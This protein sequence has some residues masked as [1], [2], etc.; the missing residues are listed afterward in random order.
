MAT[1]T[2]KQQKTF[3][4]VRI[5]GGFAAASCWATPSSPTCWPASRS[6]GPVLLTGIMALLGLGYCRLLHAQPE[7]HRRS[8]EK[9][10][11][12]GLKPAPQCCALAW[13]AG[14]HGRC[15]R[16][17][18]APGRSSRA[19]R[20]HCPPAPGTGTRQRPSRPRDQRAAAAGSGPAAAVPYQPA[21]Q[22]LARW[23][24]ATPIRARRPSARRR[25]SCPPC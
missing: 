2:L 21:R 4:L 17:V 25:L 1:P 13:P 9:G 15:W 18:P 19:P 22:S 12:E 3:A 10:R 8:L 20:R 16:A 14:R 7:P 23:S 6:R 24:Q 11:G 5:I